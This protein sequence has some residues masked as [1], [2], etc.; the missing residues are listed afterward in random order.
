MAGQDLYDWGQ[1]LSP[2]SDYISPSVNG[3]FIGTQGGIFGP[4]SNWVGQPM[5]LQSTPE[6]SA[7]S[8][9]NGVVITVWYLAW[10]TAPA[11]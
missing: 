5:T 3:N 8:S 11:Q 2:G 4:N 6:A 1:A 9:G 7:N 10:P